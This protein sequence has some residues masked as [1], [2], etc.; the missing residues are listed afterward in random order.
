MVILWCG[1]G[2][3]AAQALGVSDSIHLAADEA[4]LRRFA[5]VRY[6]NAFAPVALAQSLKV[7]GVVHFMGWH[8][9]ETEDL[10]VTLT[11]ALEHGASIICLAMPEAPDSKLLK[12]FSPEFNIASKHICW[13]ALGSPWLASTYILLLA[14]AKCTSSELQPLL[15]EKTLAA[16]KWK[17]PGFKPDGPRSTAS[18]ERDPVPSTVEAEGNENDSKKGKPMLEQ[19]AQEL[20]QLLVTGHH[21]TWYLDAGKS[22]KRRKPSMVCPQPSAGSVIIA[23]SQGAIFRLGSA[24]HLANL[25][26]TKEVSVVLVEPLKLQQS[27]LACTLPKAVAEIML[28]C[29]SSIK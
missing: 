9:G 4:E 29:V 3:N 1:Q 10:R 6:H 21:Q 27:V 8:N 14:N 20:Q 22:S 25:G 15:Q 26:W 28:A 17:V 11:L 16:N 18:L 2:I 13:E 5:R 12:N 23:R 19:A 7:S 24:E